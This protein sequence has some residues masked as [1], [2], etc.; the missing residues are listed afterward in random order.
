MRST[1]CPEKGLV[2][3]SPLRHPATGA[4]YPLATGLF[5][6]LFYAYARVDLTALEDDITLPLLEHTIGCKERR[7]HL[8]EHLAIVFLF[9]SERKAMPFLCLAQLSTLL[10]AHNRT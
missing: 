3:R 4:R 8:Y 10:H 5:I 1:G 6:Y 7:D 9:L 2:C